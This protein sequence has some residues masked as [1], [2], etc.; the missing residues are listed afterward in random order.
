[1]NKIKPFKN[2][3]K[4]ELSPEQQAIRDWCMMATLGDGQ[5]VRLTACNKDVLNA[6]TEQATSMLSKCYE[7]VEN[8]SGNFTV[9]FDYGKY[10]G[11]TVFVA[12]YDGDEEDCLAALRA[13]KEVFLPL[14]EEEKLAAWG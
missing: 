8:K 13:V 7:V 14:T 2:V 5:T 10:V 6:T 3:T 1:M 11:N 12:N 4:K 9:S